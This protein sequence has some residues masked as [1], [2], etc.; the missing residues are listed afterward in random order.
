MFVL[1]GISSR[2]APIAEIFPTI[3]WAFL[4]KIEYISLFYAG[5]AASLFFNTIFK[6]FTHQIYSKILVY[7]FYI[8]SFLV[9]IL[10]APHFTKF[11][12]PFLV[13]MLFNIIYVFYVIATSFK[14][15]KHDSILLLVGV[16]LGTIVFFLH[17]FVFIGKL[18]NALIYVNFGYVL[19]FLMLSM[20]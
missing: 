12:F 17:I 20:L 19:V 13:Y 2:Y 3:S 16:L 14:E 18:E 7:G 15:K 6:N 8:L 1:H 11:V 4:T 9:I 5:T 10:P